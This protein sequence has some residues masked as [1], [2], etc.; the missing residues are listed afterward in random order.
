MNSMKTLALIALAVPSVVQAAD[1]QANPAAA[2]SSPAQSSGS[3]ESRREAVEPVNSTGNCFAVVRSDGVLLRSSCVLRARRI[4]NP[5]RYEIIYN[6]NVGT[7]T[8]S[9]TLGNTGTGVPATGE[10]VT[11]TRFGTLNGVF[12]ATYASNGAAANRDFHTT[13]LCR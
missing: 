8:F 12:V 1:N 3:V 4:V 10:C 9:C 7:C 5:G 2:L 13:V 11:A 6:G